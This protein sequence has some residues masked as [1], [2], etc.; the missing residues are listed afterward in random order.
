MGDGLAEVR[1][2]MLRFPVEFLRVAIAN[3]AKLKPQ[4]SGRVSSR[5]SLKKPERLSRQSHCVLEARAP[6]RCLRLQNDLVQ[7]GSDVMQDMHHCVTRGIDT[8]NNTFAPRATRATST[9]SSTAHV[10]G[11]HA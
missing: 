11:W 8:R 4:F 9:V 6:V 2:W 7:T 1:V 5:L 3:E 10:S